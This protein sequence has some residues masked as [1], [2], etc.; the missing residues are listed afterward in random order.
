M[1][2][3]VRCEKLPVVVVMMVAALGCKDDGADPKPD[4][5]A[6]VRAAC[7]KAIAAAERAEPAERAA[8]LVTGCPGCPGLADPA[9]AAKAACALPAAGD[10][11]F[12]AP[13]SASVADLY[14]LPAA[15]GPGSSPEA[16]GHPWRGTDDHAGPITDAVFVVVTGKVARVGVAPLIRIEAG[17]LSSRGDDPATAAPVGAEKLAQAVA[18][19]TAEAAKARGDAGAG[20]VIF[21][22]DGRGSASAF[23]SLASRTG[24]DHGHLGI[25]GPAAKAQAH[26]I[27]LEIPSIETAAP[28]IRIDDDAFFVDE[29]RLPRG[30][31]L[32]ERL[33]TTLRKL[34]AERAPLTRIVVEA[35]GNSTV[36]D[37]VVAF[38]AAAEAQIHTVLLPLAP[39]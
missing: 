6:Q 26:A 2:L 13:L 33:E 12:P 1:R 22:A 39:E 36:N 11:W 18:A 7:Q 25:A 28:V 10:L 24:L 32:G 4:P 8:L 27:V 14:S 19:S 31:G 16:P 3:G 37:L 5:Q 34:V 20:G 15:E 38:D 17:R 21:L 35:T 30:D 23:L 9:A 29:E